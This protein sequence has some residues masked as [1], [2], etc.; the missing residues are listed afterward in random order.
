M[1]VDIVWKA[2]LVGMIFGFFATL[3]FLFDFPRFVSEW[4][5]VLPVLWFSELMMMALVS[6]FFVVFGIVLTYVLVG[7]GFGLVIFGIGKIVERLK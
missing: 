6:S 2:G 4:V 1:K 7:I 3:S 5:M